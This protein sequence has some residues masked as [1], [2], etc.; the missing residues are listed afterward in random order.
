MYLVLGTT[1][2]CWYTACAAPLPAIL[3]LLTPSTYAE[4]SPAEFATSSRIHGAS[5]TITT[6][7]YWIVSRLSEGL[8]EGDAPHVSSHTRYQKFGLRPAPEMTEAQAAGTAPGAA[9]V[10]VAYSTTT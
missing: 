6:L 5:G 3:R 4:R 7:L 10:V 9:P 8:T 2:I 1:G